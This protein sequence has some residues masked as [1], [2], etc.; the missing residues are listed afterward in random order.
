MTLRELAA[1]V[2]ATPRHIRFLIAEGL[3][4]PPD[5]GRKFAAYGDRHA[6]AVRKYRRLRE[7]RAPRPAIERV[8][9]HGR[10]KSENPAERRRA[11]A[12]RNQRLRDLGF[13]AAAIRQL[14]QAKEGAEFPLPVADGI[15]LVIAPEWLV[16]GEPVEPLVERVREVLETALRSA[17]EPSGRG[18]PE[19]ATAA[20]A[21]PQPA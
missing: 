1:E 21:E 20:S 19:P 3:C 15:T 12:R 13:P 17:E 2:G 10:R 4:P 9:D 16:S 8:L 7:I 18:A 6:A 5:G 11:A 14:L